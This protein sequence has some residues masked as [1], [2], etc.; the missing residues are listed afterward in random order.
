MS[1]SV[2]I[3]PLKELELTIKPD[4]NK[5][6]IEGRTAVTFESLVTLILQRR[7]DTLFKKL[8]KD[9]VIVSSELLTSIASAKQE[10]RLNETKL[11]TVTFGIGTVFGVLLSSIILFVLMQ[12]QIVVGQRELLIVIGSIVGVAIVGWTIVKMQSAKQG[13]KLVDTMEKITSAL[14]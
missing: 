13:G 8:G 9:P 2:N 12:T 11:I 10:S 1:H 3:S 5:A 14:S 4:L 7:V 6:I